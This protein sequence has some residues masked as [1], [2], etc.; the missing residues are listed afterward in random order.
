MIGRSRQNDGKNL[1]SK[2]TIFALKT[3]IT[4]KILGNSLKYVAKVK[5]IV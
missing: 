1:P 4:N 3:K 5:L 2:R